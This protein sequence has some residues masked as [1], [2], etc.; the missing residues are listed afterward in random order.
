MRPC[1]G[2][3]KFLQLEA[4]ESRPVSSLLP[5]G[6]KFIHLPIAVIIRGVAVGTTGGTGPLAGRV[7]PMVRFR[8]RVDTVIHRRA[9]RPVVI[10]RRVH[11]AMVVKRGIDGAVVVKRRIHGAMIMRGMNSAIPFAVMRR[12]DGPSNFMR[13]MK[14]A[15]VVI[16]MVAFRRRVQGAMDI[17]RRVGSGWRPWGGLFRFG[18][19]GDAHGGRG[20]YRGEEWV[21]SGLIL[22][23]EL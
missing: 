6:S 22:H 2:F 11:G 8:R 14:H 21:E 3:L 17:R 1:K 13:G 18:L 7:H 15:A 16:A 12:V 19:L 10:M 9:V 20:G 5:F 4:R 23:Q